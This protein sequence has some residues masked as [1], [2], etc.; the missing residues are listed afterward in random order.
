MQ[1]VNTTNELANLIDYTNLN[2]LATKEDIEKLCKHAKYY[3]FYSVVVSPYHVKYAKNLLKSENIKVCTVVGFPLGFTDS[4][5]KKKEVEIA[6]K[7]GA[8][9]IDMVV[10]IT[11]IKEKDYDLIKNEIDVVKKAI[12]DKLLKVIIE[13]ELLNEDEIIDICKI[14]EKT[15]AEFIKTST[16][17][18]GI[19]PKASN[20]IIMRKYA[21]NMKI[22]AS[23]GIKDYKTV[24]RL[25][26]AGADRIGTSSGDLIIEEYKRIDE[27]YDVQNKNS[28]INH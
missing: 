4:E 24:N 20:L 19:S 1:K 25:I 13:A 22:K 2:N 9:E 5:S 7:N 17:L 18:S 14:A 27:K 16:G 6:I 23:G 3:G 26:A 12:G 15:N 8:D 21:P 10:N 28:L 11:A